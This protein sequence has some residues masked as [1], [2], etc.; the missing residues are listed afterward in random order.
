[1][2]GGLTCCPGC[3]RSPESPTD[4]VMLTGADWGTLICHRGGTDHKGVLCSEA[5]MNSKRLSRSQFFI[6]LSILFI[7]ISN[8]IH[9]PCFPSN[10]PHPTSYSL[11][12]YEGASPHSTPRP[13]HCSNI[14]LCWGI[15]PSQ[16]QGLLLQLMPDKAILC[17]TSSWSYGPYH[18]YSGA[19][20]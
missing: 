14:P 20:S 11:C 17:Y 6:L 2:G 7:Y 18:V 19:L 15:K 4:Y 5:F 3:C 1:M 13:P 12:L 8:D 9:L 10:P 16:D